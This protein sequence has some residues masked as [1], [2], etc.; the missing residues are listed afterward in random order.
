MT[1]PTEPEALSAEWLTGVFE[2]AGLSGEVSAA[3]TSPVGTGQMARSYRV[4][5]SASGGIPTSV[6]C[7]LPATEPSV[8]ELGSSGY[9]KEVSFYEKLAPHVDIAVPHCWHSEISDDDRDFVLVLEDMAPAT[10]GDQIAGCSPDQVTR[11]S[12]ELARLHRPTWIEADPVDLSWMGT[13]D[14]SM[15][16]MFMPIAHEQ[17]IDNLGDRLGDAHKEVLTTFAPNAVDWIG[18]GTKHTAV[19]H[20]D[21]R[22]DNLLFGADGSVTVVDWQTMTVGVAGCDLAYLLGNSVPTEVR[23]TID[24]EVMEAYVDELDID[25]YGLEE[26]LA[27]VRY[28]AFQGPMITMLGAY[29]ATRTDRGDDMFVAMAERSCDQILDLDSLE[30]LG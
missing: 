12:I 14:P 10:Q 5:L 22:L 21:F 2:A 9:R 27:D 25:G 4:S 17:F 19:V 28:G 23:R 8:R 7:K 15:L 26:C 20:G 6:V 11:A 3:T 29:A 24:Q 1:I 16:G 18:A 30:L 13:D